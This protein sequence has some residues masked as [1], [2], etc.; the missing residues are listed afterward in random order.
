M[1]ASCVG[2]ENRVYLEKTTVPSVLSWNKNS[3]L[4]LEDNIAKITFTISG[5]EEYCSKM[6]SPSVLCVLFDNQILN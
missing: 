5:K 3:L 6:K 2:G 4:K 1:A